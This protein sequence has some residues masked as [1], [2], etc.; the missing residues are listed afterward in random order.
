E[1]Y[2]SFGYAHVQQDA[3]EESGAG[4]LSISADE[5]KIE[6]AVSGVG[7]R[8]FGVFQ[9]ERR[10]WLRPELR[11]GW[12]HEFGDV[13]RK[14]DARIGGVPGASYVVRGAELPRNTGVVGVAWTVTAGDRLHVFGEYG[15]AVNGRLL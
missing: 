12:L 4:S 7:A 14:L 6:S 3:F 1:P 8:V 15:L 13:E 2:A 11:A 5:Q 9:I 10:V